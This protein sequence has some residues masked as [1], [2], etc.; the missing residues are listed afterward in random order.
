MTPITQTELL[1]SFPEAFNALPESYQ[2]DSCLDFYFDCNKNLCCGPK[3]EEVPVLG[4]WEAV[5]C[6][7]EKTWMAIC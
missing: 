1:V 4:E 7:N 5:Y 3:R 6:T 2:S